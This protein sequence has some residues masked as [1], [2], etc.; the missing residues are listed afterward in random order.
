[1]LLYRTWS[2]IDRTP[3][4]GRRRRHLPDPLVATAFALLVVTLAVL[5]FVGTK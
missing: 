1:L 2:A 4:K 5:A 3:A